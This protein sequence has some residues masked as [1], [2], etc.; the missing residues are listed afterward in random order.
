[1]TDAL[2]TRFRVA[3][4]RSLPLPA[5][6]AGLGN[7]LDS[8]V[9]LGF[10]DWSI[11]GIPLVG[12]EVGLAYAKKECGGDL[13][14]LVEGFAAAPQA[15]VPSPSV[16]YVQHLLA[17]VFATYTLGLSYACASLLLRLNPGR[18]KPSE[19]NEPRDVDRARV[20]IA[21]L[22]RE[23]PTAPD[24]GGDFTDVVARLTTIWDTAV[25]AHAGLSV[26]HEAADHFIPENTWLDDFVQRT[27]ESFEGLMMIFPPYDNDRWKASQ[28][29]YG[30]LGDDGDTGATPIQEDEVP[31]VLTA[32]WQRRLV[33]NAE[34]LRVADDI[35][36]RWSKRRQ[37]A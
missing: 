27:V 6:H 37:V 21:T 25:R 17:D 1:M 23:R 35:K 2:L 30:S 8:V 7:A 19:A 5:R 32:A 34:P 16:E 33:D 36:S 15:G 20:I 18:D 29:W 13:K 4:G 28:Q 9:L 26:Q 11:W 10:P 3:T 24:R 22:G 31:D 12:H 14:Q